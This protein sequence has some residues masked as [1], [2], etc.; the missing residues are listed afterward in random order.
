MGSRRLHLAL[1]LSITSASACNSSTPGTAGDPDAGPVDDDAATEVPDARPGSPDARPGS[2]DAR[3][4]SPDAHMSGPDAHVSGNPDARPAPDAPPVTPDARLPDAAPTPDAPPACTGEWTA[5]PALMVNGTAVAPLAMTTDDHTVYVVYRRPGDNTFL[6]V[7][8][9]APGG[10]WRTFRSVTSLGDYPSPMFDPA[11]FV[12]RGDHLVLWLWGG[13]GSTPTRGV[14]SLSTHDWTT[15]TLY[16][17]GGAPALA[18]TDDWLISWGEFY[19]T[20]GEQMCVTEATFGEGSIDA[21]Q[22]PVSSTLGT[23]PLSDRAWAYGAGAGRYAFI[24][25]GCQVPSSMACWAQE[26]PKIWLQDGAFFD[27]TTGTWGTSIDATVIAS[28]CSNSGGQSK[29]PWTGQDLVFFGVD[30]VYL[31]A[32]GETAF[33][34]KDDTANVGRLSGGVQ[35]GGQFQ[36]KPGVLLWSSGSGVLYDPAA[37]TAQTICAPAATVPQDFSRTTSSGAVFMGS[38]GGYYLDL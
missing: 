5:I 4:G 34:S 35:L 23:S 19:E 2:P 27:P 33:R 15:Q 30:T 21:T 28:G 8:S 32:P 17:T 6:D 29:A 37:N 11:I 20:S 1:L 3:P 31:I 13:T 7:A 22:P 16:L 12:V 38:A 26:Y 9:Y 14:Y 25:G 36:S 18:V 10:S 24:Y